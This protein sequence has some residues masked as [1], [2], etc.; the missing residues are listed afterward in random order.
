MQVRGLGICA[1]MH[2]HWHIR[3]PLQARFES[4][5]DSSHEISATLLQSQALTTHLWKC[6]GTEYGKYGKYG[7]YTLAL[8]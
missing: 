5:L 7:K 1:D 8:A 6:Q 2:P 3:S 4:L